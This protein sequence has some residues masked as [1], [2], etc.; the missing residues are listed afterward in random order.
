MRI[1]F[2]LLLPFLLVA[3]ETEVEL[4]TNV[5]RALNSFDADVLKAQTRYRDEV[6]DA[7]EGLIR[8]LDREMEQATKKG[9]LELALAIRSKKEALADYTAGGLA[10]LDFLGNEMKEKQKKKIA[11]TLITGNWEYHWVGKTRKMSFNKD[12]KIGEGS[13]TN[14]FAWTLNKDLILTIYNSNND[15]FA[16]MAYSKATNSWQGR[17]K[18]GPI[19]SIR[20]MGN[21]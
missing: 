20:P 18:T 6:E 1:A 16:V 4:P 21:K 5:E 9:D 7:K 2:I 15:P 3:G 14:E 17:A 13:H 19:V 11:L 12:G 10:E 8:T